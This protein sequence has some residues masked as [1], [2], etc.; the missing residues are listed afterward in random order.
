MGQAADSNY[1]RLMENLTPMKKL[2]PGAISFFFIT[3]NLFGQHE[4]SVFTSTGR[5]GVSTTFVTDYQSI[6][7]NPANLGLPVKYENKHIAFGLFEVGSSVYSNAL[8]K[9]EL[10]NLFST[11]DSTLTWEQKRQAA[12]KFTNSPFSFSTDINYLSVS[13]QYDKVGGFAF[14]IRES[15]QYYSNFNST[16]SDILFRG[17]GSSYFDQLVVDFGSYTDTVAN[18]QQNLEQYQGQI[19]KGFATS[20][21]MLSTLLDGSKINMSWTREYNLSY[22]REVLKHDNFSLYAGVGLKYFQGLN[23]MDIQVR[24]G[25]LE[26]FG[27]FTPRLGLDFVDSAFTNPSYTGIQNSGLPEAVG[28]GFGSDLGITFFYKEKI[29]VGFAVTNIGSITYSGNV[30]TVKD[31]ALFDLMNEG[32]NSYNFVNE[33]DKFA[34]DEGIF[35]WQGEE[36]RTIALPT[37]IRFGASHKFKDKAEVGVDFVIPVKDVAGNFQRGIL[38]V[39]ADYYPVKWLRLSSGFVTGG[40]YI[41]KPLNIPIGVSFIVGESGTWEAGVASR[42]AITWFSSENPNL[43]GALGFLRFRI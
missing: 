26:A 24:D 18:T 39:G 34:G 35:T 12:Q 32:M 17:Y 36:E 40:N 1:S 5:A 33:L 25:K 22:G 30:F 23:V 9:S 4:M 20:P 19:L 16:V 3:F 7:I 41:N 2:L 28:Q 38:A 37:M 8:N 21:Q 42:D 15:M 11:Y 31:T 13:V 43:S 14:G 29:K 27:A 6:G 10:N